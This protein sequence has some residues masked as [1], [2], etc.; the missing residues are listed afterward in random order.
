[1]YR[2]DEIIELLKRADESCPQLR[3]GQLLVNALMV[4]GIIKTPFPSLFYVR[5]EELEASLRDYVELYEENTKE[6]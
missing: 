3:L 1:M 6:T 4:S 5:D 2:C